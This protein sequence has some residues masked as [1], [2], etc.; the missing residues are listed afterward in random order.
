[1]VGLVATSSGAE[2][3]NVRSQSGQFLVRG[4]PMTAPAWGY[5]TS[6]VEYL[7]L[8][9]LRLDPNLTA[10]S[11]ERIK[12]SVLSELRLKDQWRGLIS[13]TTHPASAD[14]TTVH[15]DSVRFKDGWGYRVDMPERIDKD[16]FMRVAVRVIL[17]EIANREALTREAELPPWLT[18]GIA[19]ELQATVLP[20]L[21]LEPEV[22]LDKLNLRYD[23]LERAREVL[24][25]RPALKFDD[26][27]LPTAAMTAP[28]NLEVYRACSQI[29]V[30]ELLRLRT[31]RESLGEM[32][33]ALPR[34]LNWQTTFLQAF[35][36]HFQ[37]LIDVDKWYALTIAN[38]VSRDPLSRW[39]L[40]TSLKQLEEILATQVQVRLDASELPITTSVTLQRIVTEWDEAKQ[41]P[42]IAEKV[43]QLQ[44]L[45]PRAALD[46]GELVGGYAEV[47]QKH[48]ETL[49]PKAKPR[50]RDAEAGRK[51]PSKTRNLL[52]RLDELDARRGELSRQS[53]PA[54]KTP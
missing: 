14:V 54:E 17:S 8:E 41:H 39:P 32:L 13:F 40:E 50:R 38:I 18:E 29:F 45:L 35:K 34:N 52:R 15:V 19:A 7:S 9:Y 16:R 44:A 25:R 24:R 46:L 36:A 37:R 20:T 53:N 22:K 26:L 1:M 51:L 23:P 49:N 48:F 11:L 12:Q 27:C 43:R 28:E 33:L 5:P 30:H 2:A 21:A 10:V 47:L 31:G 42:V 3:V 6:T 4:L